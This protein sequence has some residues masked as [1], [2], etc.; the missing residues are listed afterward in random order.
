[1]FSILHL[2][3]G[4][5]SLAGCHFQMLYKDTR[6]ILC[7]KALQN[8]TKVHPLLNLSVNNDIQVIRLVLLLDT[9]QTVSFY[10]IVISCTELITPVSC[11]HFS[12]HSLAEKFI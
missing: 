4:V 1:M 8:W 6:I 3:V 7:L 10:C 5:L 11:M 2:S 9:D 12:Q